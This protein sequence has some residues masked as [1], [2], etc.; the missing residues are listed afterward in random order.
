MFRMVPPSNK[1]FNRSVDALVAKDGIFS[2]VSGS[3]TAPTLAAAAAAAIAANLDAVQ[4]A[5]IDA[6]AFAGAP[7]AFAT[8]TQDVTNDPSITGSGAYWQAYGYNTFD[9]YMGFAP[10]SGGGSAGGG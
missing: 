6:Q 2:P 9:Q 4:H 1:A 7:G 10:D 3:P 5:A 8:S